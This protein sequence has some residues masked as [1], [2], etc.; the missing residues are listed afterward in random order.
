MK[1]SYTTKILNDE[2]FNLYSFSNLILLRWEARI[3]VRFINC[4]FYR[5]FRGKFTLQSAG[6]LLIIW[7]QNNNYEDRRYTNLSWI[8]IDVNTLVAD[9]RLMYE[10]SNFAGAFYYIDDKNSEGNQY[11]NI[12]SEIDIL[13]LETKVEDDSPVIEYLGMGSCAF[14]TFYT[15]KT[16]YIYLL[17]QLIFFYLWMTIFLQI[18]IFWSLFQVSFTFSL[19]P[20]S[21]DNCLKEFI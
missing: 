12:E 20:P 2:I 14:C 1:V 18:Y 16:F 4:W 10:E 6:N 17:I 3:F 21:V 13:L 11:K 5:S 19:L 15:S 9:N 8:Q 7:F